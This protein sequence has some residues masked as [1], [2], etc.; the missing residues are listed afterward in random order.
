MIEK[1][2]TAITIVTDSI[3]LDKFLKWAGIAETGGAAK[4]LI[5]NELVSVNG[6]TEKKRSRVLFHGDRI[7]VSGNCYQVRSHKQD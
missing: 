1:Q 6:Q 7:C 3:S 2:T 4:Y 5:Q